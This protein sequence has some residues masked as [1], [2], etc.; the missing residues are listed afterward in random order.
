M[1]FRFAI[2]NNFSPDHPFVLWNPYKY[3]GNEPFPDNGH[4]RDWHSVIY[5]FGKG[6]TINS[7]YKKGD[8]YAL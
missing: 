6:G 1:N 5:T 8:D 2:T 7:D 4:V 3:E